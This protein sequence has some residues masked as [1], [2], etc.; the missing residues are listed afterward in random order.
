MFNHASGCSVTFRLHTYHD[1]NLRFDFQHHWNEHR[2]QRPF[3]YIKRYLQKRNTQVQSLALHK[4][5]MY[6]EEEICML[7]NIHTWDLQRL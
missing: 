3:E 4:Y 7:A 2:R 5:I 6:L 1:Q